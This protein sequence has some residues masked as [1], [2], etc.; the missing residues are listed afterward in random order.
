ME[1]ETS[2]T[3]AQRIPIGILPQEKIRERLYEFACRLA[4]MAKGDE[5]AK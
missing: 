2:I 5:N 4:G 1:L 3:D